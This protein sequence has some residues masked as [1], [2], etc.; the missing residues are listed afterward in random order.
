[1]ASTSHVKWE[2]TVADG[3]G[4]IETGSGAVDADYT[5]AGRFGDGARTEILQ[6]AKALLSG[7]ERDA[8][9]VDHMIGAFDGAIDRGTIPEIRLNRHDLAD[10]AERLQVEGKVRTPA[11]NAYAM[12]ALGQRTHD[13]APEKARSAEDGDEFRL[14]AHVGAPRMVRFLLLC[15]AS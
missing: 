14:V 1:M 2:G 8:D 12:T 11:G 10:A 6:G 7:F 9:K 4:H 15:A 5:A 3:K 13:M